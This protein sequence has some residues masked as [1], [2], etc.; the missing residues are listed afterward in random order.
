M[1][2]IDLHKV[3]K[4]YPF[5]GQFVDSNGFPAVYYLPSY[6]LNYKSILRSIQ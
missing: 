3:I 5:D 1:S 2:L 4:K 6:G